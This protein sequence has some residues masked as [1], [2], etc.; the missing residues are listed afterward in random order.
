MNLALPVQE[1]DPR[2]PCAD[3]IIVHA[4]VLT[5]RYG[6]RS[7]A[8]AIA[9][10]DGKILAVGNQREIEDLAG[11][12]TERIDAGGQTVAPGLIDTHAHVEAAGILNY[13]ISF[14]GVRN[15]S[16]AQARVAEMA[17]RTPPGEWLCAAASGI[18]CR[19]LQSAAS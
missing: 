2:A 10:K 16:E 17:A 14:E 3:L 11:S 18:R 5:P 12:G 1:K 7:R 8:E 6:L 9:V 13:T 4:N 15:V 19:N